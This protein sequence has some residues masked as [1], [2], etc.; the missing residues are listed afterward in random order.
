MGKSI[1]VRPG[2]VIDMGPFITA[3]P[4]GASETGTIDLPPGW[5]EIVVYGTHA[6][7]ATDPTLALT[8]FVDAAQTAAAAQTIPGADPA[9]AAYAAAVDLEFGNTGVYLT[10]GTNANLAVVT[11]GNKFYIPH[12]IQYVYTKNGGTAVNLSLAAVRIA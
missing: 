6:A 4:A 8:A 9:D 1:Q 3:V 5:Y 11:A 7:A 12:G 2:E 10:Y